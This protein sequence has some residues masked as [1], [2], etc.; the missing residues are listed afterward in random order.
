LKAR[1]VPFTKEMCINESPAPVTEIDTVNLSDDKRSININGAMGDNPFLTSKNNRDRMVLEDK[2]RSYISLSVPVVNT[3]ITGA[4]NGIAK[5]IL[6]IPSSRFNDIIAGQVIYDTY[7]DE[8]ILAREAEP[9]E[10]YLYGGRIIEYIIDNFD[11]DAQITAE[12]ERIIAEKFYTKKEAQSNPVTVYKAEGQGNILPDYVLE[13][14]LYTLKTPDIEDMVHWFKYDYIRNHPDSKITALLRI[15]DDILDGFCTRT[16]R[17][18]PRGLRPMI[19]GRSDSMTAL[20]TDLMRADRALR[21]ISNVNEPMMYAIKYRDLQYAFDFLVS[22][23]TS[24]KE[25]RTRRTDKNRKRK[26][27]FEYTS[28]KYGHI[29]DDMLKK[30]QDFSGRS[31]IVAD[32]TLSLDEVRLP[33]AI[34]E[35]IMEYHT[36][37]KPERERDLNE[38]IDEVPVMLNRAP[39]L[40]RLS[41]RSYK[42]RLSDDDSI[43]V[44]PL[45]AEGFNFDH[46]GDSMAV[47]VPLS[48]EAIDELNNLLDVKKNLFIPASGKVTLMPKQELVYGLNIISSSYKTQKKTKK[49]FNIESDKELVS[50]FESH[51]A[52]VYAVVEYKGI[53]KT[54]GEHLIDYIFPKSV[55][56][57]C[58][59][60]EKGV[61][62]DIMEI[63]SKESE[64]VFKRCADRIVKIAY[65]A[66]TLYPPCISI[67]NDYSDKK[68]INNPFKDFEKEMAVYRENYHNGYDNLTTYNSVYTE[69]FDKTAESITENI[70]KDMGEVK[71]MVL[72]GL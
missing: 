42:V 58:R 41:L 9:G 57:L 43:G 36:K 45:S 32:P 48:D 15:T 67:L 72:S 29:R 37:I 34:A 17:V 52:S 19:D 28:T 53:S 47:H 31:V 24:Q 61:M 54:L 44:N 64:N 46:D 33:R 50:I 21:K 16:V 65:T 4:D 12:A 22:C 38:V 11:K 2:V 60:I 71:I 30:V 20:Y 40:H 27:I 63:L 66:A 55:I 23:T 18:L 26:S 51:R 6:G 8:Y 70:K 62:T 13:V 35:K 14:N 69:A 49:A 1:L 10:S 68:S 39:T 25:E 7:N 3:L 59:D 56:H 5:K